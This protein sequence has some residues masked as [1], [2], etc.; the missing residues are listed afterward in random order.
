MAY[1]RKIRN[2]NVFLD[3]RSY[4]GLCQSATLPELTIQTTDYRG[5]GM[6]APMALD[7]GMEAMTSEMVFAEFRGELVAMLGTRQLFVL[8]AAAQAEAD[9]TDADAL[10]VTMRGRVTGMPMSEFGAGS[11]VTL[12][13]ALA[14]DRYKL[15]IAGQL[16]VDIDVQAG[17]RVIGGVDQTG[18]LRS[19]MGL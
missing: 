16:L 8:R 5:G 17:K 14:V 11:D 10:I 12:S 2:F 6:D 15:E 13:L 19:A 18:A 9:V 4:F 1:P 3:G 7:M